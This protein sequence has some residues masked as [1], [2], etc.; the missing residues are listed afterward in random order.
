[1]LLKFKNK[2]VMALDKMI[3]DGEGIKAG[4]IDKVM[5]DPKEALGILH[6]IITLKLVGKIS[7]RDVANDVDVTT[8][9]LMWVSGVDKDEHIKEII[10]KWYK[11]KYEVKYAGYLLIVVNPILDVAKPNKEVNPWMGESHLDKDRPPR[12]APPPPPPPPPRSVTGIAVPQDSVPAMTKQFMDNQ[13]PEPPK[14]PPNRLI[15]DSAFVA[16]GFCEKCG[17]SIKSKWLF[18]KGDGCIQ[19]ECE[20]F[21]ENK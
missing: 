7:I 14:C 20:N 15:R 8:K 19:P 11:A 17:S 12:V 6:E 18:F 2:H 4:V 1:M 13:V 9:E 21:W 5:V 10:Q 3:A 16:T